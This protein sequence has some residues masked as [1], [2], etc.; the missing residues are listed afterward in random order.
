MLRSLIERFLPRG[1]VAV[2][3]CPHCR[4][5]KVP[6]WRADT[7]EWVHDDRQGR[8]FAHMFCKGTGV[9]RAQ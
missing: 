4:S 5:G 2:L 8:V 7:S 6:R 3:R 9:W 1:M